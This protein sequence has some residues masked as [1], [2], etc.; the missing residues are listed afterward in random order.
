MISMANIT[1][2]LFGGTSAA[3]RVSCWPQAELAQRSHD[4]S[5]GV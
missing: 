4:A 2:T 3:K 1:Y 5:S